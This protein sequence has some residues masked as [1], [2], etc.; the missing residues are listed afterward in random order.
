MREFQCLS[1]RIMHNDE[2]GYSQTPLYPFPR[3][4]R[5]K[6]PP[7]HI[8]I[9]LRSLGPSSNKTSYRSMAGP[10]DKTLMDMSRSYVTKMS[11][12]SSI[13]GKIVMLE[14]TVNN[15]ERGFQ[16]VWALQT[17]NKN[18]NPT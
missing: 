18:R 5:A 16:E 6:D 9:R 3:M 15:K 7:C 11:P 1:G 14:P 13:S 2:D 4:L 12:L 17:D 8:Q 10:S